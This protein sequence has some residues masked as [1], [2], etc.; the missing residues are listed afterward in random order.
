M[1]RENARHDVCRGAGAGVGGGEL[2][3]EGRDRERAAKVASLCVV[4]RGTGA[5]LPRSLALVWAGLRAHALR[6]A[7]GALLSTLGVRSG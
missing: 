7:A 3:A 2:V 4:G 6:S 1:D 5:G